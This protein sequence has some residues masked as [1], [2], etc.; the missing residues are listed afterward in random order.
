MSAAAEL[1]IVVPA[2]A[3]NVSLLRRAVFGLGDAIGLEQS[4][5][6]DLQ[7]IVTEAAMNV[8]QHAYEDSQGPLEMAAGRQGDGLEVAIRDRG[9]G[10]RPRPADPGRGDLRL[11]L[12][13]IAALSDAFELKGS[14]GAGTEVRMT[15]AYVRDSDPADANP[16]PGTVGI[17]GRWDLDAE[18]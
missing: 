17:D 18:T 13:L 4:D 16:V 9:V 12:P 14:A 2:R 1:R 11:G 15:F 10:F 8:V 7:T 3:E 5:L 6:G